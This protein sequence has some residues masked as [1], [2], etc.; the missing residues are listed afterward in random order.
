[1][2][3]ICRQIG[4]SKYKLLTKLSSTTLLFDL[5]G[6]IISLYPERTTQALRNLSRLSS[7][8]FDKQMKEAVCLLEYETGKI[9]CQKFLEEISRELHITASF[10]IVKDAWNAMLGHFPKENIEVL[11]QLKAAG[12]R[13]LLLSNTN[14]IHIEEVLNRLRAETELADFSDIFDAV[15]YS[16]ELGYRKPDPCIYQIILESHSLQAQEVLFID[17]NHDNIKAADALGIKTQLWPQNQLLTAIFP[18]HE[19]IG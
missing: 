17:D 13:L 19:E 16:Q 6:V 18:Q 8:R 10:E 11:R 12:H 1:M 3:H 14:V 15:Y 2:L 7:A 5:G 9:D 4:N